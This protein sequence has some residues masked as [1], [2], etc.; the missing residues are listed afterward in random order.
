MFNIYFYINVVLGHAVILWI[1][2]RS[3]KPG[4]SGSTPGF[5]SLSDEN[6]SCGPHLHMIF[7]VG[8]MPNTKQKH[9]S[10]N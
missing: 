5:T 6:L 1:N 8:G 2:P 10:I 9:I 7:A 3:C 4:V